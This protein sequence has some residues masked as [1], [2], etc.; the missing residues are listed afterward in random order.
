MGDHPFYNHR[1]LD[2][3][4]SPDE[5]FVALAIVSSGV[6]LAPHLFVGVPPPAGF[7]LK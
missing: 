7:F 3:T 2:V 6:A 1:E 5:R 4:W